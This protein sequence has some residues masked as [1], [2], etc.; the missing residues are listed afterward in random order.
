MARLD[1]TAALTNEV[2]GLAA[3][4]AKDPA[5][6]EMLATERKLEAIYQARMARR[7]TADCRRFDNAELQQIAGW[8]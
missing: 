4:L 5:E 7:H 1:T 6:A 3:K 2:F 8:N